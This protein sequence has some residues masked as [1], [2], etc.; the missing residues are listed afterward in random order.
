[1]RSSKG[2]R[3]PSPIDQAPAA[4][5]AS[6]RAIVLLSVAA[7]ASAATT[8]ICDGLLPQISTDLRVTTGA[9]AQVITAYSASYGLLQVAYG[10][11]GDRFGKE[12]MLILGTVTSV[13]TTLA[14]AA[15]TT[16]PDLV[17]ARLFAG[18]TASGIIPLSLAWIGDVV[19][20]AQRQATIARFIGGQ[21]GGVIVG[22]AFGGVIGEW[23]G[24]RAAFWLI[25]AIYVVAT[26]GLVLQFG[27]GAPPSV[28]PGGFIG[29]LRTITSVFASRWA[30]TVL[31][32]TLI[33]GFLCF[34]A[35]AYVTATL[36]TRFGLGFAMAGLTLSAFGLGG[37]TY[38]LFAPRIVARFGEAGVSRASCPLFALAF[39]GFALMPSP[40]VGA[41]ASYLAGLAYY[42]LHNVLQVNATQMVPHA[43][44]AAVAL[45]ATAF[46]VGQG[47]GVAAAAPVVDMYGATPVYLATAFCLPAC[48]FLFARAVQRKVAA[49][50]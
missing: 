22:L 36:H 19:P 50:A 3:V 46:F 23:F 21:I 30:R 9:A 25:A 15:A 44:G 28:A 1:M 49:A 31:L 34:G 10:M 41:I 4:P 27:R 5:T 6:A 2:S 45:F 8:R 35:L 40:L 17:W 26:G 37:L 18:A 39:L 42:C 7:F 32:M 11:L 43:R 14:C 48:A 12:R 33:E 16:L 20:Y 13:F 29:A 24:W 38:T 47:F